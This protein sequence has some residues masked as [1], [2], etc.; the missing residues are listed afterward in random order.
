MKSHERNLLQPIDLIRGLRDVTFKIGT[1]LIFIYL[2]ICQTC[3]RFLSMHT[4][5]ILILNYYCFI[6]IKV[7]LF[8]SLVKKIRENNNAASLTSLVEK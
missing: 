3:A 5:L 6:Y 2:L 1:H 7:L 4:D 8:L